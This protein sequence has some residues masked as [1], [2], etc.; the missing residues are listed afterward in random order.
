MY[1]NEL[2]RALLGTGPDAGPDDWTAAFT[3]VD[4]AM[5]HDVVEAAFTTADRARHLARLRHGETPV[6]V[7]VEA[8]AQ[9]GAAGAV[10]V[11]VTFTDVTDLIEARADIDRLVDALQAG[12]D[13]VLVVAP[14]L[15]VT[16][17]KGSGHE[18][19]AALESAGRPRPRRHRRHRA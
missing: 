12:S 6:W 2:A 10:G 19:F 7:R 11:I 3:P 5:V 14:D 15:T 9:H 4:A 1:L 16:H 18:H 17:V 8:V 13:L